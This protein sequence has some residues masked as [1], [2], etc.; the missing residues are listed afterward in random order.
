[1]GQAAVGVVD[2]ED[3]L[4]LGLEAGGEAESGRGVL[5]G[6]E[7]V[8]VEGFGAVAGEGRGGEEEMKNE[9]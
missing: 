2:E 9:K 6:G 5:E 4:A 1:M 8:V 7:G 3:G